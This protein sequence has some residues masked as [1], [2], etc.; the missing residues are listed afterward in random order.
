MEFHVE[1]EILEFHMQIQNAHF[2]AQ[3]SHPHP[4]CAFSRADPKC[5]FSCTDFACG[6]RPYVSLAG[7][8]TLTCDAL[9]CVYHCLAVNPCFLAALALSTLSL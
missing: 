3:I 9:Y 5:A 2:R 7:V 6:F 8:F 4:N 1:N